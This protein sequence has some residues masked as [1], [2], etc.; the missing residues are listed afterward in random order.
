MNTLNLFLKNAGGEHVEAVHQRILWWL[1]HSQTIVEE[2]FG[3][4]LSG[5][6]VKMET[7]NKTYDL[8][9][10]NSDKEPFLIELK[11]WSNLTDKQIEKQV[12]NKANGKLVYILFG[13]SYL[14]RK[15]Y[16][17]DK[18][19]PILK[20]AEI[21]VIGAEDLS[22]T[23]LKLSD[24]TNTFFEEL[25]QEKTGECTSIELKQFLITYAL[26]IKRTNDW[27]VHEAYKEDWENYTSKHYHSLFNQ[28]KI[29]LKKQE[30]D[31]QTFLYKTLRND[32][33]LEITTPD[34]RNP[35]KNDNDEHI[36]DRGIIIEDIECQLLF[37]LQNKTIQIVAYFKDSKPPKDWKMKA[38]SSVG[39]YIHHKIPG[40]PLDKTA[41][42]NEV[43]VL[44]SKT[45]ESKTPDKIVEE[46]EKCYP[47]YLNS[48]NSLKNQSK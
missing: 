16:L 17:E 20:G 47:L 22:N 3:K 9:I 41:S 14:E 10:D 7:L 4:K 24:K 19:Q 36:P 15:D 32:V 8:Q 28:V 48:Y 39:E 35:I 13:P 42:T 25:N 34:V 26:K 45:I 6:D 37:W 46:I 1:F 33:K 44:W 21:Q 11:M 2:V 12:K 18:T 38:R 23:L 31:Y 30:K 43:I 27:L 40:N 5:I 29:R